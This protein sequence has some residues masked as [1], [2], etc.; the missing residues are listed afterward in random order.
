L[1]ESLASLAL[2]PYHPQLPTRREGQKLTSDL[3]LY[4]HD[5]SECFPA[6]LEQGFDTWEAIYSITESDFEAL[7]VKLGY[8]RRL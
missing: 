1:K 2:M 5:M 3:F 6:F 7:S 8:K 4:K